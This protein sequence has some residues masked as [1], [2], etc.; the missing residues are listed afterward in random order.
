MLPLSPE[1][2]AF[3]ALLPLEDR[4]THVLL[5]L[6]MFRQLTEEAVG[7]GGVALV[8]R[9]SLKEAGYLSKAY[10]P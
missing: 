2:R 6:R 3:C 8:S 10:N 9:R 1:R 5:L 7:G 4:R